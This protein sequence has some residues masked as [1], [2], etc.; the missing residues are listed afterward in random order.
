MEGYTLDELNRATTEDR[1]PVL[2]TA[3]QRAAIE[4]GLRR[5]RLDPEAPDVVD[6]ALRVV[7]ETKCTSCNGAGSQARGE[8]ERPCE[9][10]DGT[11]WRR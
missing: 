3:A 4:E 5:W 11:G 2:I 9:G 7:R 10:C 1:H 8:D 6:Q